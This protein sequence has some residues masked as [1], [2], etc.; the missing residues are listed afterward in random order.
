MRKPLGR[1][2]RQLRRR[3]WPGEDPRW[4]GHVVRPTVRR[5]SRR[6]LLSFDATVRFDWLARSLLGQPLSLRAWHR[7]T[8]NDKVTYR[9]LRVEDPTFAVFSD[10]LAMREYVADR[11]GQEALPELL[12]V[13]ERAAA[14][15]ERV[16]PFVVKANHGAGMVT[17][18][19]PGER[20]SAVELA[21]ADEWLT[22][23]YAWVDL[24]WGYLHARRL[25]L[26]EELLPG[27]GDGPPPDFK[28]F[29][30]D[31]SVE[32]LEM[33]TGRF[34]DEHRID[35]RRPD[36]TPLEIP[37]LAPGNGSAPPN[38]DVMLAWATQL[39]QGLD[40]VRVDLYDLGDRV[41]VG[42]LT[43][44]PGG[45]NSAYRPDG[46][47]AWFGQAWRTRPAHVVPLFRRR[48]T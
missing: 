21:R 20:L 6:R 1:L 48:R 26:A 7:M 38:L 9:R 10:K 44:Y 11:L 18:V 13:A 25:L 42:E 17:F 12:E 4:Q 32:A 33:H 36:W 30:F 39:G 40:F 23:D 27:S 2:R 35:I 43:P 46:I 19:Q 22:N 37:D 14:L 28:F 34:G 16:G 45:G 3:F 24:E 5:M 8:F 29:V 41:L 31:G 47:D 15:A